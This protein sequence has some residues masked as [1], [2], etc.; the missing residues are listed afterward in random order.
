MPQ[1]LLTTCSQSPVQT[2]DTELAVR[3]IVHGP[4][5]SHKAGGSVTAEQRD[6]CWSA[7]RSNLTS[8][9]GENVLMLSSKDFYHTIG[10]LRGKTL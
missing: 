6:C 3:Y 7:E 1:T 9:E 2:E 5:S 8:S 4:V 10:L